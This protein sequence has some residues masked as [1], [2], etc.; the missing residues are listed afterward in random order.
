MKTKVDHSIE[1]TLSSQ[2]WTG[3]AADCKAE[4]YTTVDGSRINILATLSFPVYP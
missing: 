1:Y 3:G 4:L 2:S